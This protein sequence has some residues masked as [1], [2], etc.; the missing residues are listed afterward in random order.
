MI[1]SAPASKKSK[2]VLMTASGFVALNLQIEIEWNCGLK[3]YALECFNL[4][5]QSGSPSTLFPTCTVN[6]VANPPSI[7]R[8]LLRTIS[9][10]ITEKVFWIS[11]SFYCCIAT[12]Y[13]VPVYKY[14][15]TNS[16]IRILKNNSNQIDVIAPY[17]QL[18]NV[19]NVSVKC[20]MISYFDTCS[21][22]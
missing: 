12:R 4:A 20:K 3:N 15:V 6:W 14:K 16:T 10:I 18:V 17:Y 22:Y 2:C 21:Q 11:S 19:F 7:T 8:T 9:A 13:Y 5:D 1:A